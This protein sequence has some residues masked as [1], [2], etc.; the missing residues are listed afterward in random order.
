MSPSFQ[1]ASKKLVNLL[2]HL[3]K[4]LLPSMSRKLTWNPG[5]KATRAGED[6]WDDKTV[7]IL[8]GGALSDHQQGAV[9][10]ATGN[11]HGL[12]TICDNVLR[13]CLE[14]SLWFLGCFFWSTA[15]HPDKL[16][17]D[18]FLVFS[19]T[20]QILSSFICKMTGRVWRFFTQQHKL[21]GSSAQIGSDAGCR[22]RLQVQVA[23]AG[24]R[25][26]FRKM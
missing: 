7:L 25:C 19:R 4:Y 16:L 2:G 1:S 13:E 3:S 8:G 18:C 15:F 20:T 24:C 9:R 6:G 12:A 10:F 26:R 14:I 11:L 5:A 21:M 22:C 23:G 17:L